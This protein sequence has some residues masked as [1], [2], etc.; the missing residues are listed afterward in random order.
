[1][2]PLKSNG[3]CR[4][5]LQRGKFAPST[6]RAQPTG[7]GALWQ[8]RFHTVISTS[9]AMPLVSS[10][11]DMTMND[12]AQTNTTSN[13][14]DKARAVIAEKRKGI[15]SPVFETLLTRPAV[16]QAASDIGLAIRFAGCLPAPLREI[17]ICT[18]AAHWNTE[19]EWASHSKLAVQA[20]ITED[21]LDAIRRGRPLTGGDIEQQ[22]V[23]AFITEILRD[24]RASIAAHNQVLELLDRPQAVELA[25][26]AGYFS[27]LSFV[28][29]TFEAASSAN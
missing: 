23:Y 29:N 16:A 3:G 4:M 9:S 6:A 21:L 7:R 17:A 24:G 11:S 10:S 13:E 20:G 22:A 15:V 25:A 28:I 18:V 19:Y 8:E 2:P 12:T 5:A 26:I 14:R 27:L 1:M